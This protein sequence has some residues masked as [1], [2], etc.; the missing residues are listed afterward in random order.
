MKTNDERFVLKEMSAREQKHFLS[1][2]Q[3]YF[4]FVKRT[5]P[6]DASLPSC[7]VKIFGVFKVGVRWHRTGK[8]T[9][10]VLARKNKNIYTFAHKFNAS[11]IFFLQILRSANG[12]PWSKAPRPQTRNP[13]P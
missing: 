4:K 11:E 6:P 9:S 12:K 10:Q 13:R 1:A 7:L 2:A 5:L 3:E 8:A